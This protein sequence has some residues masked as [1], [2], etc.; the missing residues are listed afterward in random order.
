MKRM[1]Q[2]ALD[3]AQAKAEEIMRRN[4]AIDKA[5]AALYK[6]EKQTLEDIRVARQALKDLE[7][8]TK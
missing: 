6:L 3:Q 8:H 5:L 4:L 7:I 1:T 2:K